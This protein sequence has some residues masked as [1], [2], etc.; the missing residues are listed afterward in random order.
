MLRTFGRCIWKQSRDISVL[1]YPTHLVYEI[2]TNQGY[3]YIS[4]D[5]K[6][7]KIEVISLASLNS[8]N[9]KLNDAKNIVLPNLE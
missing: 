8:E 9:Y 1:N 6:S 5:K 7:D 2:Y 3:F 4:Q